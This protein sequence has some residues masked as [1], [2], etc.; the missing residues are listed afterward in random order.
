M[1][2]LKTRLGQSHLLLQKDQFYFRRSTTSSQCK[3]MLM[4][5]FVFIRSML[6]VP[7]VNTHDRCGLQKVL[8]KVLKCKFS[9]IFEVLHRV[10]WSCPQSWGRGLQT[11]LEIKDLNFILIAYWMHAV[12]S[13]TASASYEIIYIYIFLHFRHFVYEPWNQLCKF[14]FNP[15]IQLCCII[16]ILNY[17]ILFIAEWC[18]VWISMN[19]KCCI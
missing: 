10:S 8:L 11:H 4:F 18:A 9:T 16:L 13:Y 3:L 15:V 17:I 1:T 7:H 14:N 12:N 2:A 19:D 5:R 6:Q